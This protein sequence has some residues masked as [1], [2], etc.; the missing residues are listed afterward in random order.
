M[1]R[2]AILGAAGR[3][4]QALIR[5]I[6]ASRDL[7]LSAAI[8][9]AGHARLGADA[10]VTAGIPPL[11]VP[12]SADFSAVKPSDVIIDFTFHQTV[13][14]NARQAAEW[15]IPMII[16]TTGLL[17]I[18]TAVVQKSASIIPIV[19]APNMSLGVNLLFAL[20]ERAAGILGFAYR[21][22]VDE[23]HHI[24]K[25][26]APSGTALRLA[27]KIAQGRGQDL[28]QV[29]VHR[30]EGTGDIPTDETAITVQSFRQGEVVGDHTVR[31][32]NTGEM[33]EL[34]HHLESRDALAMGALHAA[35]WII[36]KPPRLYDMQDVLGL[37]AVLE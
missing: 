2:V 27:E 6:G 10:G 16:G 25:K 19:W 18:E 21:T 15:N 37:T 32:E 12:I 1:I 5:C 7:Q 11:G 30:P 13:P 22:S 35:R 17:D 28:H 14:N 3:M 29:L 31:F 23:T 9:Q 4:G 8:E 36:G 33:I 24:H 34:T 20:V 26:D